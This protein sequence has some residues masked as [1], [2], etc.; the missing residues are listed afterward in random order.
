[1]QDCI[2]D[3]TH[4][5]HTYWWNHIHSWRWTIWPY[6]G[7]LLLQHDIEHLDEHFLTTLKTRKAV[8]KIKLIKQMY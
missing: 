5:K 3:L 1:M 4:D 6:P 7:L 8:I 2:G